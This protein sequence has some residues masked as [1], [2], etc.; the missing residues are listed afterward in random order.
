M[1]APHNCALLKCAIP[2][3]IRS[4][5]KNLRMAPSVEFELDRQLGEVG[6]NIADLIEF[7]VIEN[8][9]QD[10]KKELLQMKQDRKKKRLA[11]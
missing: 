9:L 7:L 4:R 2:G 8:K 11:A 5:Q 1:A 3:E 6:L 10:Y